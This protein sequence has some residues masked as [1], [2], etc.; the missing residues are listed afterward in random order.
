MIR[1]RKMQRTM[2]ILGSL[3]NA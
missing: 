2:Y 3:E 1:V